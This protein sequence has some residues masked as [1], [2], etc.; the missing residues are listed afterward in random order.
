MQRQTA[1]TLARLL[2]HRD[3]DAIA[4]TGGAA[5]DFHLTALGDQPSRHSS[6]DLDFVVSRIDAVGESVS[7]DFLVSHYH[8][9]RS[10]VPKFLLQLVD[11]IARLR[12]DIFPDLAGSVASAEWHEVGATRVKVLTLASIFEHK[13]QTLSRASVDRPV[14]PKHLRDAERLGRRLGR[15]VPPVA[16]EALQPDIYGGDTDASCQK[17]EASRHPGFPLAPKEQVFTL[18]GW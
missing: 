12:I 2:M 16:R 15:D 7:R 1:S 13:L 18:L 11:P 9:P 17:C 8:V 4:L 14:D 6:T 10:G 3:A 5:I